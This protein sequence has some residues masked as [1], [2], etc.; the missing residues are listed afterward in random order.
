MAD[1]IRSKPTDKRITHPVSLIKDGVELGLILCD[2]RGNPDPRAMRQGNNPRTSLQIRQGDA[3]YSDFELPYTPFTQKD[4]S[5]GRGLEEFEEDKSRYFDSLNL[6]TVHGRAF[7]GPKLNTAGF[8]N[9]AGSGIDITGNVHY[10]E[11][12]GAQYC[13]SQPDN[14]GA[15]VLS[16]NGL[17]GVGKAGSTV[18]GIVTTLNLTGFNLAGKTIVITAGTGYDQEKSWRKIASNTQGVVGGDTIVPVEAWFVAPD[19][20]TEFVIIG[21]DGWYEISG[22]GLTKPVTSVL[23]YNDVAY[24]AQGESTNIRRINWE[25]FG[26]VWTMTAA[27]D[28]T[29]KA[30]FLKLLPKTTGGMRIWKVNNNLIGVPTATYATAQAWGVNLD[31]TTKPSEVTADWPIPLVSANSSSVSKVTGIEGYGD[32][33]TPWILKEDEI[34]SIENG[35]YS[36]VPLSE[37]RSVKHYANGRAHMQYGVYLFFSLLDGMERFYSN[38]LDD[39]GPNRDLGLPYGR[40]GKIS[41]LIPYAGQFYLSID[42]GWTGYSSILSWNGI[43]FAE[44]FRAPAPN[45]RIRNMTIQTTP[46]DQEPDRLWFVYGNY[47]RYIHVATNPLNQAGFKF[48]QYSHL[49]SARI[50]GGFAEVNKFWHETRVFLKRYASKLFA[51]FAYRTTQGVAPRDERDINYIDSADYSVQWLKYRDGNYDRMKVDL[52]TSVALT[53]LTGT[54]EAVVACC[55]NG[56]TGAG[57]MVASFDGGKNFSAEFDG[58]AYRVFMA[59]VKLANGITLISATIGAESPATK[60]VILYMQQTTPG[61]TDIT[62]AIKSNYFNITNPQVIRK[63]IVSDNRIYAMTTGKIFVSVDNGSTWTQLY[64]TATKTILDIC[65]EQNPTNSEDVILIGN[66][67]SGSLFITK[68]VV[69]YSGALTVTTSDSAWVPATDATCSAKFVKTSA[70]RLLLLHSDN[71]ISGGRLRVYNL[72]DDLNEIIND[73]WNLFGVAGGPRLFHEAVV[74]PEEFNI[75]DTIATGSGGI[76][77]AVEKTSVSESSIYGTPDA[78]F[79]YS[80]DDGQHWLTYHPSERL[81]YTGG[82]YRVV[83][84]CI[85]YGGQAAEVYSRAARIFRSDSDTDWVLVPGNCEDSVTELAISADDSI[86]GRRL[87]FMIDLISVNENETPVL[88][89]VTIDAVTRLK[90]KKSWVLSFLVDDMAVDLQGKRVTWT[91]NEFINQLNTWADSDLTPTPITMRYNHEV[92]DNR[93]VFVEYPTVVPIEVIN[94]EQPHKIKLLCQLVVTEA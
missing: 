84:D 79:F 62:L 63:L 31:F 30:T 70:G 69:N 41:C 64:T 18:S 19:T 54:T 81:R 46:D 75:R 58:T 10:F 89:A 9:G 44:L 23:V 82:M 4:F 55:D 87:Q 85:L 86:A 51:R 91:A 50:N 34:G 17:R 13:V 7:M 16:M 37:M 43:G 38:R 74:W 53:G 36:P 66:Y 67:E 56:D 61:T 12:K 72:G 88:K 47:M 14:G 57:S 52:F 28:G 77:M 20:T 27:D 48:T 49:Q 35:I 65:L 25:N 22:H 21:M 93:R 2:G 80:H 42:A 39:M 60:T 3:D 1:I 26:G 68:M 94:T 15:P 83:G 11:Y 73:G 90:G 78:M 29:N 32:P 92:H 59:A 6:N 45:M 5:G 33:L 8:Y 71:S 24:F 76:L 40:K